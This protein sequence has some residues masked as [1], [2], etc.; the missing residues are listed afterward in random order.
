MRWTFHNME[1]RRVV[2]AFDF[3]LLVLDLHLPHLDGI[4]ISSRT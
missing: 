3:D 2:M 4:A 1:N